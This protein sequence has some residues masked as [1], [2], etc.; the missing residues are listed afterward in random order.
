M[1][2]NN[3]SSEDFHKLIESLNNNTR[4][5][6]KGTSSTEKISKSTK[7]DATKAAST[8]SSSRSSS[9]GDAAVTRQLIADQSKLSNITQSVSKSL[10]S[11]ASVAEGATKHFK[12]LASASSN[13]SK[14]LT[15]MLP[16]LERVFGAAGIVKLMA[17]ALDDTTKTYRELS[18]VGQTFNGSMLSMQIAAA[19]AALPL[20]EFAE[21]IKKNST[22]IAAI[23]TTSFMS[24]SKALRTSLMDVGQ[25]GLTTSQLNASLGQYLDT[26]RLYGN[27]SNQ[28]TE[29]T[30]SNMRALGVETL[31]AAQMTGMNT[32]KI[33]E[34]ATAAL[35]DESVRAKMMQMSASGIDSY[36]LSLNKAVIYMSALP[37]EAGKTLSSMLAQTA[38]RGSALL[39]DASQTF[40]DAGMFGVTDLMDNMS[41]KVA[42]NTWNDQDAADFNRKFVAEGMKNM[43][44]LQMQAATGNT[45]AKQ[46]IVMISEMKEISKKNP[47]EL[48]AQKGVTNFLQNL[49]VIIDNVSGLIRERF[50]KGL[51]ALMTRFEGF[52]DSPAWAAFSDKIGGM[53]ERFGLFLSETI[54]PERL[55]AFGGGLASALEAAVKFATVIAG[56]VEKVVNVFGWLNDKVGLLGTA[57]VAFVAWQTAKAATGAVAGGVGRV[58]D[59]LTQRF[60]IGGGRGGPLTEGGVQS[61]FE[62]ALSRYSAGGSLRVVQLGGGGGGGASDFDLPERHEHANR[63]SNRPRRPASRLSRFESLADRLATHRQN[64]A[65]AIRRTIMHPLSSGRSAMS[66]TASMVR[67][68]AGSLARSSKGLASGLA[69]GGT[70]L[71]KA[72]GPAVLGSLGVEALKAVT[73]DFKGKATLAAMAQG[74]LIGAEL[75]PIGAAVGAGVGAIYANWDAISDTVSS[76]FKSIASF[77]YAG[78]LSKVGSMLSPIT[79]GIKWYVNTLW[80]SWKK[81]GSVVLSGLRSVKNFFMGGDSNKS[82]ASAAMAQASSM[83]FNGNNLNNTGINDM[84]ALSLMPS[85]GVD[86]FGNQQPGSPVVAPNIPASPTI[87]K[88]NTDAVNV[89]TNGW[90]EQSLQLQRDNLE[91]RTQMTQF[92]GIMANSSNQTVGGILDMINEQQKGNRSMEVVA[93]NVI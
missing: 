44:S 93:G 76:A 50:Y 75:G 82:D 7:H 22:V 18:Q 19:N 52:T 36:G 2:D 61:A 38:G 42:N 83:S 11:A 80:K 28:S 67:S 88:V 49:G 10:G 70:A 3:I 25:L 72:G 77:D 91:T 4:A 17:S 12:T 21:V 34:S 26:Q 46:A 13:T 14:S 58:R 45:A 39:S 16:V 55:I 43:A 64:G 32:E 29:K 41:K 68:G 33:S 65:S 51:E 53:A 35:R 31:K 27:L 89:H 5:I 56:V 85:T 57:L 54:T 24:M 66:R 87:P 69:R 81:V 37:G 40:I 63:S 86:I 23:G 84:N 9:G 48:A 8:S 78:A 1:A 20:N 30:T 6:L 62:H 79:D 92:M 73:P 74:A 15:Q 90:K 47:E 71:L 60:T 59:L